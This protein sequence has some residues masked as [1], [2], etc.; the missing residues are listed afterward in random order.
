MCVWGGGGYVRVCVCVVNI[1]PNVQSLSR[2]TLC[3]FHYV[4]IV[5]QLVLHVRSLKIA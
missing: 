5:Y 3:V 1:V 2:C 4:C